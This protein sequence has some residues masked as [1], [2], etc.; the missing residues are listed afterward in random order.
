MHDTDNA[1]AGYLRAQGQHLENEDGQ[2]VLLRGVGLGN[3][4]L[5]EGY[6]WRF[7]AQ[8]DRPRRME[9]LIT[10]LVG[11]P[12]ARSFWAAY[13]DRFVAEADVEEL[14]AQGFNSVRL[15]LNART[16]L[17]AAGGRRSDDSRADVSN[18][19]DEE[20][21]TVVDRFIGWCREHRLYVIIDLHGAPG[22]QTGTNIDDSEDDRPG[23]F[24][25]EANA[26][27]TVRLW[28]TIAERYRD[29]WIVAGYD[30]LNEPLPDW[31]AEHNA[32]VMPLYRRIT[33]AIREVDSRHMII[34][35]GVHW[36]TD[37][38]IFSETID[39]NTM[40]EF[41]KYW[42]NPDAESLEPYLRARSD[43]NVP[44]FMGE[45]GE[46]NADWYAGAFRLFEDLDISWN[47]WT[48]KKMDTTNSPLSVRM[49]AQWS[50]LQRYA[51]GGPK[52]EPAIAWAV[53][54]EHLE[55]IG[56]DRCERHREVVN[57]LFRRPDVRIPAIF[58][59][60]AERGLGFGG[61]ELPAA[62]GLAPAGGA[63]PIEFRRSDGVPIVAPEGG[64]DLPDFRHGGGEPWT[65][66][67]WL[68]VRLD[69]GAWVAYDFDASRLE[70]A[71]G[72]CEVRVRCS[73]SPGALLRVS[74]DDPEGFRECAIN[75]HEDDYPFSL[76][77]SP[78]LRRIVLTA[79][80]GT[81]VA[82]HL[83][84]C[85]SPEGV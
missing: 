66:E 84:V 70:S 16:I 1:V 30:L 27:L 10:D 58:Y 61:A 15:P 44:I 22:G 77:A 49:P 76:A 63:A 41:H 14:S 19:L 73:G 79:V 21:M 39:D 23:L 31:F 18:L 60:F 55:N 80:R 40:L 78:G 64:G 53:L 59:A 12:R 85:E 42:N 68:R 48:W 69:P 45:G 5:P 83:T 47:F 7:P 50:L 82:R 33:E 4:F 13:H 52:P 43:L 75:T 57:A 28:R 35:E 25:D 81:I 72:R 65:E 37:W 20:V 6:M 36:A 71:T 17:A 26:E 51:S 8:A 34:L 38:S 9:R 74:L 24:L 46:N 56:S 62:D 11:E 32:A 67:Q 54:E 29:E 2:R 3:W